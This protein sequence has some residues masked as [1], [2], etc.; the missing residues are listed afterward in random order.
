MDLTSITGAVFF[1]A[2]S[3]IAVSYG[4]GMRGTTLGGEKGAMLPGAIMGL[5]IALFSGSAF[6]QENFFLL[7]AAGALG[8]YFGGSMS[9]M[10]TTGLGS[11]KNPPEDLKRSLTGLFVKGS[12]WWAIFGAVVGMFLSFLTGQY[13]NLTAVLLIFG[14][15]PLFGFIGSRLFDRPFDEKKGIHPKIYFSRTRPEGMGVLF[16]ILVGLIIFMA[17]YRDNVALVFTVG[18]M[19]S[20]GT[21][22]LVGQ[23]GNIRGKYPNKNGWQFLGKYHKKG[24]I[25]TWKIAECTFGGIAGLGVA[26]TFVLV[27]NFLPAYA[28]YYN[29]SYFA[30]SEMVNISQW[31]MPGI[32][33]ALLA[34]DLNRHIIKRR[35]TAEEYIYMNKRGWLSGQELEIALK[36]AGREPSKAFLLYEK[37]AHTALFPIYCYIPLLFLFLGSAEVAKLVSFYV[38]YFVLVEQQAFDRFV[39]FKTVYLWRGVLMGLGTLVIFAQFYWGWTP[40][41]F[42]TV[43]L[44][45]WGYEGLTLVGNIARNSPDRYQKPLVKDSSWTEAYGGLLTVHGYF[46][47]CLIVFTGFGAMYLF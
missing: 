40:G 3:I 26:L 9:Y 25:C 10:Q 20:G 6:L 41:I 37:I 2:M 19:L 31:L 30:I 8:I 45:G 29:D 16:G 5:L 4:W 13:Y 43:L 11:D 27:V 21:G 28:L 15:M 7:T 33:V 23:L 35:K 1:I 38:L 34:L 14:T 42:E 46:I 44:Y 12:I 24:I 39:N 47:L 36:T 32:F 18:S 17:I 22:F